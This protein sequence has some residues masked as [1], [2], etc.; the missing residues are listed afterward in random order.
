VAAGT[1]DAQIITGQ[2]HQGGLSLSPLVT[3]IVESKTIAVHSMT[4]AM[5]ARGEEV[6]SL[7][8]GEPDFDPPQVSG[9]TQEPTRAPTL[10]SRWRGVSNDIGF[11]R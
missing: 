2:E 3:D 6:V 11:L 7:A 1:P 4:M 10:H 5:K 8:V 9:G